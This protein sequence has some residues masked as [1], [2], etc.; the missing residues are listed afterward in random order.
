MKISS[1]KLHDESR[2]SANTFPFKT[3]AEITSTF[4][5]LTL[6]VVPSLF[7]LTL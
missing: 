5:R 3:P 2:H 4:Q 7:K 1:A 6:T